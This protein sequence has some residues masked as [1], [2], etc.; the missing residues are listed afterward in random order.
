MIDP[1]QSTHSFIE[2]LTTC[3]PPT[4]PHLIILFLTA[5]LNEGLAT[6]T[7]PNIQHLQLLV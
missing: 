1:F 3:P 7:I 4:I 5:F 2:D 6:S